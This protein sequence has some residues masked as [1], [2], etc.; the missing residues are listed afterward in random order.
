VQVKF[1]FDAEPN[2]AGF[3]LAHVFNLRTI[4]VTLRQ[5]QSLKRTGIPVVLSPIYLNPSLALW[6]TRAVASIFGEPRSEEELARLLE[7]LKARTLRLKD[8]AGHELSAEGQNRPRAEYD[9]L[10]RAVLDQVEHLLPNSYLEMNALVKTLRVFDIPFT[11][12]PYACDPRVFLD[13]DPQPFVKAHGVRDFVLQVGRVEASK[14]Q[15]LLAYALRDLSLPVVLLGG[16]MQKQYLA[17]CRQYGPKDLRII[18]HLPAARL[19]SAYAAARVHA[20]PSWIETCGLVTME[21]ALANANVVVSIAGYELEYYRDLAYYC[22]P[23]D[24]GSIR[25]AV[26]E[27]YGNYAR[28][29]RPRGLLKDL[30]LK[31]Y[32]WEQAAQATHHAYCRV[33]EG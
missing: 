9:E 4:P 13:P 11:V 28:D 19:R 1:S 27:A 7:G 29:A 30:I 2:A 20:L 21:A 24:V 8:E 6:G 15:L 14:N 16:S 33:L 26:V 17:W 5:V 31:Q 3:D 25:E 12:V 10:Q 18:P 22:D 32:T 23:S